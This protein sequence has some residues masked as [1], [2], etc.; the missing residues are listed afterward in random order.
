[1]PGFYP[2]EARLRGIPDAH[3]AHR[4]KI[5]KLVG[6]N[7]DNINLYAKELTPPKISIEEELVPGASVDYKFAKTGVFNDVVIVFYDVYG[8]YDK[9]Y[10]LYSKTW[11][12][13]GVSTANNY[14]DQS[15]IDMTDGGGRIISGWK[16]HNSWLKELD[17]SQL[18]YGDSELK[19]VTAVIAYTWADHTSD[20]SRAKMWANTGVS[21]RQYGGASEDRYMQGSIFDATSRLR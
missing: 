14:M 10:E 12:V 2:S 17:N 20:Y 13:D 19:T 7:L 9:L 6:I 5:T 8:T 3:R 18:S 21:H 11:T 16:L 1:M 15:L 4:W